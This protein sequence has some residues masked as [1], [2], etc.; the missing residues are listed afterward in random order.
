MRS[1]LFIIMAFA[2]GVVTTLVVQG[3]LQGQERAEPRPAAKAAPAEDSRNA[4]A[5]SRP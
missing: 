3:I 2:L 5:E 4:G 1:G